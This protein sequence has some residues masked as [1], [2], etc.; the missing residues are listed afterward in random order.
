MENNEKKVT[1]KNRPGLDERI[2]NTAELLAAFAKE[3]LDEKTVEEI[4]KDLA[5]IIN[6]DEGV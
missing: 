2:R 6:N 5:D 3:N 4:T 1:A